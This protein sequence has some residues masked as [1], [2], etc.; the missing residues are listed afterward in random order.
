M[1]RQAGISTIGAAI[2]AAVVAG[3]GAGAVAWQQHQQLVQ[4]RGELAESQAALQTAVASA[5]AARNQL[6][7]VRKELDEQKMAAE[8]LRAELNSARV[9]FEAEKQHGERLRAELTLAKEQLAFMRTRQL[10]PV[11]APTLVRP[12]ILRVERAGSGG[13]AYGAPI[14]AQPP[15]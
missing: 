7:V 11:A 2:I 6:I 14:Q 3:G 10:A 13:Q 8:Q 5:N 4:V 9:L 15:R 12:Q 1:K